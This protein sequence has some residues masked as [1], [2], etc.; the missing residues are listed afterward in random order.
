VT[1][2]VGIWLFV[3][4]IALTLVLPIVSAVRATRALKEAEALRAMVAR[5]SDELRAVRQAL[6]R[7]RG[8]VVAGN[9]VPPTAA[10]ATAPVD[11][12]PA[13][14]HA[15]GGE[16]A[17]TVGAV[18]PIAEADIA[19]PLTPPAPSPPTAPSP[20]AAPPPSAALPPPAAPPPTAPPPAPATAPSPRAPGAGSHPISLE[21]R[22]GS[23]WLL[24]AGL[25]TLVLGAS[26][27]VKYAF[28]NNWVT[29]R[30]RVG[31]G[32]L[33]GGVLVEA[34]RRFSRRGLAFYGQMIAGAGIVL[35]YVAI[36]AA[37]T[38]YGLLSP[39]AGFAL[40]AMVTALGALLA[41]RETSQG[42][43][44]LAVLG[45][46]LTPFLV[47]GEART[48]HVLFTYDAILV[49][50][51]LALA[52]LHR[53]PALHLVSFTMTGLTILAWSA[54]R[55]RSAQWLPMELWITLFAALFLLIWRTLPPPARLPDQL[56]A[57]LLGTTPLLYHAAS[58][59]ILWRHT[60]GL[61]VY[62]IAATAAGLIVAGHTRR[63]WIRLATW[64]LVAL[65][66]LGWVSLRPARWDPAPFVA[67]SGI[68]ALHLL[69][70]LRETAARPERP[71][72]IDVFLLHANGLWLWAGLALLL[73]KVALDRLGIMTFATAAWQGA[74][75]AAVL[76]RNRETGLHLLALAA[77]LAAA[78]VAIEYDG[79]AVT[80]A[81]AIEGA[82]IVAL[83]LSTARPWVRIGGGV[84]LAAA[85]YRVTL[86]LLE[87]AAA[88][89]LPLINTR[90]GAALLVVALLA[91]AAWRYRTRPPGDALLPPPRIVAAL[92]VIA[93]L[94]VVLWAS[95]EVEALF[96][97]AAWT[98]AQ[99][100]AGPVTA[101]SLARDVTLSTLWAGYG[102]LLIAIGIRR[103]YR[104]VRLLGI[105]LFAVTV[106]KVFAIDLARLDRFY[107]ILSTV[108]LGLLLLGASYLYQRFTRDEGD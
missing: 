94:L 68:Y 76:P 75:A 101:A 16:V 106:A 26:Y 52:R 36:F 50:G 19:P 74:L 41:H 56:A 60:A 107:R 40:M 43:A 88:G 39:P 37:I 28:E 55:Y 33:A 57:T 71:S 1:A 100:G 63:D 48:P 59:A 86:A 91:L 42:L 47:G 30:M 35:L 70:Q 103:R 102:L 66:A 22:I 21:A 45:G 61:L 20:P 105:A 53:W 13:D 97:R 44:L 79:P 32:A 34:G 8:V 83:G 18:E 81:W 77:A 14:R 29:P 27:F 10:A 46:F 108:G 62:L 78:G 4:W 92:V 82:A 11:V 6:E 49:V 96:A 72:A 98:G 24:Y 90:S 80:V 95:A 3:A 9:R 5:L 31:L 15:P 12:L 54:D 64:G 65:P 104:P 51:T 38:F 87:P 58:L 89:A 25:A 23:R 85:V 2:I 67:L 84:L 93:N 73:E 17:T 99:A 69:A 7:Q